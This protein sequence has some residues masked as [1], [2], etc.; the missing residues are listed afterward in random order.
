MRWKRVLGYGLALWALPFVLSFVLFGVR[1]SN[2]ALFESL[3][4]VVG[5][6]LAVIAALYFFRDNIAPNL[7]QG[8][9][10]GF[11]WLTISVIVDVPIFLGVFHMS[12]SDYGVDIALT[13]LAFPAITAC[14]ALAQRRGIAVGA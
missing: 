14:I 10:L 7:R 3:I 13:Y 2:R 9:A 8:L 1:E 5:V 11:A 12:P 4:T 6:S